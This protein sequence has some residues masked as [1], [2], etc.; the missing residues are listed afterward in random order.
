ML[1]WT[2]KTLV[3]IEE[4]AAANESEGGGTIVLLA[5]APKAVMEGELEARLSAAGLL[6]GSL[7]VVRS[8]SPMLVQVLGA[9]RG[10]RYRSIA[11]N[12]SES[13]QAEAPG[14]ANAPESQCGR[15]L[16]PARG[17]LQFASGG[18]VSRHA[19]PSFFHLEEGIVRSPWRR[20]C[21][22]ERWS[23][24]ERRHRSTLSSARAGPRQGLGRSR[25]LDARA[26]RGG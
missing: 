22:K 6:R 9:S 5:D 3:V 18:R 24:S 15:F 16:R 19:I 13:H 20:H 21:P 4:L 26:R 8:G 25:A 17:S 12:D 14:C 7:V 11:T 2:D 23:D 10:R 1:G